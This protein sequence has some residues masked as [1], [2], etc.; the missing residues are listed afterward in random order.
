MTRK[1][2]FAK[3]WTIGPIIAAL[4]G[5]IPPAPASAGALAEARVSFDSAIF[6]EHTARQNGAPV[7]SLEPAT[8]L[9]SGERVV[10]LVNWSRPA[11]RGG[12]IGGFVL[13]NALPAHLNYLQSSQSDE[14]VSVD[15]GH[16][17]G[18]LGTLRIA[19]RVATLADVT[20]VRWH[21]SP[22]Q[23]AQGHGQIAYSG[24]V[25]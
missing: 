17:W 19:G 6:V 16:S 18:H 2:I 4:V 3:A 15:H 8:R 9:A 10:T 14:E 7:R 23:A 22:E 12:D 5:V 13:V 21:V 11:G 25:R 24:I 20:H 1:A